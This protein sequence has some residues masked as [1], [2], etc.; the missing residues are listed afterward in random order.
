MLNILI[1]IFLKIEKNNS[2]GQYLKLSPRRRI[3]DPQT[4][5]I[6][7]LRRS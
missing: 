1:E 7:Y 6:R 2:A 5:M 3:S 4:S